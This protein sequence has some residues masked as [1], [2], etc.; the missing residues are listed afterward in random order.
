MTQWAYK[1]KPL[2]NFAK[3]KKA[4]DKTGEAVAN[5]KVAKP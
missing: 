1:G 4:G 2:Y 3:D 5:W